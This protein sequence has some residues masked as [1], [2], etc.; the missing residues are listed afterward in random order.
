M[1]FCYALCL[2]FKKR[3]QKTYVGF[4]TRE[5][6]ARLDEHSQGT[7]RTTASN[8]PWALEV[9]ISFKERSTAEK[10]EQYLKK[11]SGYSFA[12]RHFWSNL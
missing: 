7:T 2:Y 5:I 9:I 10:F 3:H 11:G 12:K 8:R 6:Q 4:T 1:I